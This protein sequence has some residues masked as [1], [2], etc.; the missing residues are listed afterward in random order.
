M[1]KENANS[2]RSTVPADGEW[3]LT[4]E[5]C[6]KIVK[7]VLNTLTEEDYE[8]LQD[9]SKT[10]ICIAIIY[11]VLLLYALYNVGF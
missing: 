10:P 2:F 8:A 3:K 7:K 9:V 1:H 5:K 11:W 6:M 4:P